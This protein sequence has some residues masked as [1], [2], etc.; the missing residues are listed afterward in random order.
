MCVR[1]RRGWQKRKVV[2]SGRWV[3]EAGHTSDEEEVEIE[4]EAGADGRVIKRRVAKRADGL[5][6]R[7]EL[8]EMVDYIDFE[9]GEDDDER[10]VAKR[11]AAHAKFET[12]RDDEEIRKI[13]DAAYD[14]CTRLIATH[15]DQ[16]VAVAEALLKYETLSSDDVDKLMKGERMEKPTVAELL[17][18]EAAKTTL[19]IASSTPIEGPGDDLPDIMPSPA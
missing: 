7:E 10:R 1:R 3:E 17:S 19:P 2:G 12:E 11:A 9:N 8:E 15:W 5:L 18:A 13:V 4:E 6:D 14:E 16:L